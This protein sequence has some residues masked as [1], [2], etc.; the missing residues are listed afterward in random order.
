MISRFFSGLLWAA[1]VTF[2]AFSFVGFFEILNGR[3]PYQAFDEVIRVTL[4][5]AIVGGLISAF[6]K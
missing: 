3:D 6:M 1:L 2:L 4:A 5:L